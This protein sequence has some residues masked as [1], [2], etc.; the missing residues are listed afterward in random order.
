M[1]MGSG[2]GGTEAQDTKGLNPGMFPGV[3]SQHG[4]YEGIYQKQM[5]VRMLQCG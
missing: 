5:E 3:K 4:E 1:E 2:D